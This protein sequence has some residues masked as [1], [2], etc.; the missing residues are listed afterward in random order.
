LRC[1]HEGEQSGHCL[2]RVQLISKSWEYL[3]ELIVWELQRMGQWP[4]HKVAVRLELILVATSGAETGS[5]IDRQ[6]RRI[7]LARQ[8][9]QVSHREIVRRGYLP[10]QD[11][12]DSLQLDVAEEVEVVNARWQWQRVPMQDITAER[13]HVALSRIGS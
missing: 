1:A 4:L 6:G 12:G 11:A 13:S 3:A 2:S 9:Y 7:I 10:G 8:Q 5:T